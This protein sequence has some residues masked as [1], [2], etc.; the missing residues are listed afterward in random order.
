MKWLLGALF[1][2]VIS[3]FSAL[4]VPYVQNYLCNK[5]LQRLNDGAPL[6]M[7]YQCV[8]W[9][10]PS[11]ISLTGLTVQDA[12]D[13][14]ICT[15]AQVVLK[16]SLWQQLSLMFGGVVQEK[17][18]IKVQATNLTISAH[19]LTGSAMPQIL[20]VEKLSTGLHLS[21]DKIMCQGVKLQTR[22]SAIQGDCVFAGDNSSSSA[23]RYNNVHMTAR[24]S[25]SIIASAD[26]AL[27]IPY[28]KLYEACYCFSGTIR[29]KLDDLQIEDFQFDL[30][31]ADD[32]HKGS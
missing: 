17:T 24:L 28:F 6:T 7:T 13:Q 32:C 3:A 2:L 12:Q 31:H 29:G 5:L 15:A 21:L 9:Q 19:H 8:R 26:L 1:V 14:N 25:E 30:L 16:A 18:A 11:K 4:H 20:Q 23:V 22:R 10:G 27:F